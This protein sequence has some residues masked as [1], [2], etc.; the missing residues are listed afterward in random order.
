MQP[1]DR[2]RPA[3][4]TPEPATVERGVSWLRIPGLASA[5]REDVAWFAAVSAIALIGGWWLLYVAHIIVGDAVSRVVQAHSVVLSRDPH[6]AAIGFVWPPLPSMVQIP[7][8]L[9]LH[10]FMPPLFAGPIVSAIFT[11]LLAVMMNRL[12]EYL[13]VQRAWRI[14]LVTVGLLNPMIAYSAIN[15]MTENIFL[16]FVLAATLQLAKWRPGEQRELLTGALLIGLAFFVRYE[17]LAFGLAGV[18]ALVVRSWAVPIERQRLEAAITAFVAPLAYTVMLWMLWT[19]IFI[20]DPFA[21]LNG[22]GSNVFYTAGIRAGQDAVMSPLY[23]SVVKTTVYTLRRLWE[24]FPVYLP[25]VA[26]ASVIAIRKRDRAGLTILGMATVGPV[27][28]WAQV[29]RGQL[30][31]LLRFWIYGAA[32]SPILLALI[33]R[34]RMPHI[35]ARFYAAGAVLFVLSG[36]ATLLIMER[37]GDQRG[38]ALVARA[39]LSGDPLQFTQPMDGLYTELMEV[40]HYIDR[41]QASRED[42]SIMVDGLVHIGLPLVI[43]RSDLVVLDPDRDFNTILDEPVDHVNYILVP[44]FGP[45]GTASS[46]PLLERFPTLW[47]DGAPWAAYVTE[48]PNYYRSRLFRV[49]STSE[50]QQRVPP[51][52]PPR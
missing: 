6:L 20:A 8:V 35:R 1:A 9:L 37:T 38:E 47:R 25:L 7:F 46:S 24:I 40:S 12:L 49:L 3:P 21:F 10:L 34:D 39:V 30:L 22:T 31:D 4:A 50:Q 28:E 14:V 26:A 32:F 45:S 2:L 42:S 36:F 23:G 41:L 15:G 33:A 27:F 13:R 51:T 48:F 5:T 29:V 52:A 19:W 44:E 17:A 43:E 18:M 16:T 11:G